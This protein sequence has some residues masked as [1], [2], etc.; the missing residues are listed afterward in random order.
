M[1]RGLLIFVVAC[2]ALSGCKFSKVDANATVHISGRALAASGRP[3]A[4][5][6]VRLFKEADLGEALTGIVLTIG[7]LGSVCL[8]PGAPAVCR[9]AQT[10]TTAA[11][12]TYTFTLKG[13]DTQGTLGTE[14][15]L[16]VVVAAPGSGTSRPSSTL[17]FQAEAAHIALPDARLWNA[18]PHVT[19]GAG[20]VR[21]RWTPLPRAAGASPS[22]AAQLFDPARQAPT[23]SQPAGDHRAVID[24]RILE[25]HAAA[26][27]VSGH[28]TL[29][30]ASGTGDVHASYLSS[31]LPVRPL[32]G[33][34]PSRHAACSAVAGTATLKTTRQSRC[35]V[36]D[37]DLLTPARLTAAD[38]AVATGAV[39]DLG[40]ARPI[41]LVVVRGLAGSY[42]VE[43]SSDGTTYRAITT[44][45]DSTNAVQPAGHPVA[46]YVRVRS[47]SGLDE[48]LM[49]EI[50]V[51]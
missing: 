20:Q 28:A 29:A 44:S 23:W 49:A 34:P 18:A 32:L 15:T 16:D 50:S 33:A 46:R 8:L 17:S 3:L 39:V 25:D 13:S 38:A 4:G 31:R 12:G 9:Q 37:G 5:A 40:H 1:R 27:A 36:T 14:A 2:A 22:Y 19:E 21:L 47:P 42:L 30:G 6:E 7:T 24:A 48:S 11:D 10:A 45:T 35:A 43:V 51:W 26:A 41:H